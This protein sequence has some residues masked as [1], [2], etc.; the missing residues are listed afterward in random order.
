VSTKKLYLTYFDTLGFECVINLSD[1]DKKAMWA[2]LK[3]EQYQ[4][5]AYHLIMRAKANPQRFPEI[6]TFWSTLDTKTLLQYTTDMPQEM[7]DLIRQ[8]GKP[9][10]VTPKQKEV[11][12]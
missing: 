7:A 11:I 3:G 4:L 2:F 12:K 6:Y 8:Q 9:V 10:Y 1:I 5:P